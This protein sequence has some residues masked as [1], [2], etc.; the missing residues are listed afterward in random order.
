MIRE[1]K[2]IILLCTTVLSLFAVQ[3]YLKTM[4]ST[5]GETLQ[6]LQDSIQQVQGENMRLEEKILS[7]SSFTYLS[8]EAKREG[9]IKATYMSF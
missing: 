1:E 4:Y 6:R 2:V 8:T 5:D 3:L 7:L 9:F